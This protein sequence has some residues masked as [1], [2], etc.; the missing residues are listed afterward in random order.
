MRQTERRRSMRRSVDL[1]CHVHSSYWDGTVPFLAS[2]V[3]LDGIW[4]ESAFALEVGQEVLLAF[5]PPG[6]QQVAV[7][8]VARIARVS[9]LE[10]QPCGMGLAFTFMR[11]T[12]RALLARSL[13]GRPPPLP[14]RRSSSPEL[15]RVVAA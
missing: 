12:D 7:Q 14:G 3:S 2:D 8:A 11:S 1:E 4:L 6:S 13:E 9:A 15:P 5:V 10:G